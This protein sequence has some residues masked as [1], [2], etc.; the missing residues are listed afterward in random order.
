MIPIGV[1]RSGPMLH[2]RR[3]DR[4]LPELWLP[5]PGL[6]VVLIGLILGRL[7]AGARRQGEDAHA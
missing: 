3:A 2:W 1:K 6:I 4:M 7:V 5:I